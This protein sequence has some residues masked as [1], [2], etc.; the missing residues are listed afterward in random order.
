MVLIFG[1]YTMRNLNSTFRYFLFYAGL[2]VFGVIYMGVI[3]SCQVANT[4][5]NENISTVEVV[6]EQPVTIN[7]PEPEDGQVSSNPSEIRQWAVD[8]SASSEFADDFWGEKQLI[9]SPDT[10]RC[11]DYQTAWAS[12]GSD[13][14]ETLVLTYTLAVK[15]TEI[16]IVETFNPNQVVQVI[17]LGENGEKRVVYDEPPVAVDRPCPYT[18]TINVDN[19]K[20]KSRVI[21]IVIDQSVLGLGWNEIDAVELV[22]RLD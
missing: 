8:A 15:V 18:L 13:T 7:Q 20:F 14:I 16:N 19:M 17:V 11:G 6:T 10:K 12:A 3:V 22:G 21:R 4:D 9:G 1:G 5:K 2:F